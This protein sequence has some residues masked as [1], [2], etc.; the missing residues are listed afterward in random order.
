MEQITDING[1]EDLTDEVLLDINFSKKIL[2]EFPDSIE[3][4]KKR[5]LLEKINIKSL[6]YH[7]YKGLVYEAIIKN[8]EL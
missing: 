3:I 7:T 8:R 4:Y 2:K 1:L 6:P 5:N